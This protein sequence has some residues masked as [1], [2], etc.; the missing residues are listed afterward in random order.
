[1]QFH[2][3][4]RS[5]L[6]C[7]LSTINTNRN[8]IVAPYHTK[9]TL[10]QFNEQLFF[11]L[12]KQLWWKYYQKHNF[13]WIVCGNNISL[14]SQMNWK[15]DKSFQYTNSKMECWLLV[16]ESFLTRMIRLIISYII[17]FR[18]IVLVLFWNFLS[19]IISKWALHLGWFFQ[20]MKHKY[21]F[22]EHRLSTAQIAAQYFSKLQI[23]DTCIFFKI[24][25]LFPIIYYQFFP[26]T[27]YAK[28][29]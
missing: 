12:D 19:C 26:M 23:W 3:L 1:M 15:C 29:V 11:N 6:K 27:W 8:A 20:S 4:Q 10:N 28:L 22:E 13:P 5:H 14:W 25:E 2:F 24:K 7:G 21:F 9:H 17:L 18:L 16:F